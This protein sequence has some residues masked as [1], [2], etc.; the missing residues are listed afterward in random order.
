MKSKI[1]SIKNIGTGY[2]IALIFFIIQGCKKNSDNDGSN[3]NNNSSSYYMTANVDGKSWEA[4]VNMGLDNSMVLGVKSSFNGVN[5]FVLLGIKA[6]NKDSSGVVLI[7][8][9]NINLN[10]ATTFNA[11]Q[12][13]EGGYISESSP[14]SATYNQYN[15]TPATGGSGTFT[16]TAFD[17]TA[18]IIE[19]SFNGVFGS[20]NGKPEVKINNGKFRCLY[21]TNV[22]QLPHSGGFKF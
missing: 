19:G 15:T 11:L 10:K 5:A 4:N 6:A 14:G 2:A 20:L 16:V 21:T 13:S 17:Q 7:F 22:N 8:P 3:N 9:Q 18:M 1:V 12:Y